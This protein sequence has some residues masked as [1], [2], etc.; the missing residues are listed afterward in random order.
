M[1]KKT[2]AFVAVVGRFQPLH[3]GHLQLLQEALRMGGSVVV[4]LGSSFGSRSVRN[5][6]TWEERRE[7]FRQALS[8]ADFRRCIFVPVHDYFYDNE[9]WVLK[10]KEEV[11]GRIAGL[12]GNATPDLVWLG[13][14]KD[15]STAAYLQDLRRH[16]ERV[17]VLAAARTS[18]NATCL[19][20]R[21]FGDDRSDTVFRDLVAEERLHILVAKYIAENREL[22]RGVQEDWNFMVGERELWGQT[23]YPV[24]VQTVDAIVCA[25]DFDVLMVRRG[26]PPGRG[27]L[28]LPGG[29][30]EVGETLL[31]AVVREVR[32]ET[33]LR[34]EPERFHNYGAFDHPHR[35]PGRGV[36]VITTVFG[37]NLLRRCR[38]RAGDDASALQWVPASQVP[39]L[40]GEMFED[41]YQILM[42]GRSTNR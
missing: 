14:G 38:V 4:V 18:G 20:N 24:Q 2:H 17:C 34:L 29:H 21:I 22:L 40:E 36:R 35:S 28:A 41:H 1:T 11:W 39:Q 27:L 19:R 5:P 16:G 33:G 15:A 37:Y 9:R 25:P 8:D 42:Y 32:E 23:P 31:E 30:V 26:R 3:D 7:M 13:V 12:S 10:L 6:W